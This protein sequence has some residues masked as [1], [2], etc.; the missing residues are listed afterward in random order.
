MF[1]YKLEFDS[2]KE[3]KGL[4]DSEL[5][6]RLKKSRSSI[7]ML[8]WR[9]TIDFETLYK[10]CSVLDVEPKDIIVEYEVKI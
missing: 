4:S 6:R 7:S 10:L 9:N 1:G 5:A 3:R 2:Y 8:R